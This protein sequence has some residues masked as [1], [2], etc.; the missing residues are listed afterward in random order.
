MYKNGGQ[1]N[2]IDKLIKSDPN[3]L[4]FYKPYII[5]TEMLY[6]NIILQKLLKDKCVIWN[7]PKVY[8]NV[9]GKI[10]HY[11]NNKFVFEKIFESIPKKDNNWF[12][13][14]K[15]NSCCSY[16]IINRISNK[17]TQINRLEYAAAPL[18]GGLWS[19]RSEDIT[20]R[21]TM[22]LLRSGVSNSSDLPDLNENIAI[23]NLWIV[24]NNPTNLKLNNII[25]SISFEYGGM[26]YNKYQT[27]DI[28]NEINILAYIFNIDGI[29]YKNNKIYIP[30]ILPYN[31]L[32]FN[33]SYHD[34]RIH[35]QY[36]DNIT[37]CVT[38]EIW[39]NICDTNA[40]QKLEK[41]NSFS[42]K[43]LFILYKKQYTGI[44]II[45]TIN[46]KIKINFNHPTYVM[47]LMNISKEYVQ[48]IKIFL[49]H[50]KEFYSITEKTA[51]YEYKD[52]TIE[53]FDNHAIIWINKEFLL[54]D[55]LNENINFSVCADPYL[56]IENT[57][58]NQQPVELI[59]INFN[60]QLHQDG[61]TGTVFC[62]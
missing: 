9:F 62:S 26:L 31:T 43:C 47:Y 55:K 10:Q 14:R 19:P 49:N 18:I 54:F 46:N 38:F 50:Y 1:N 12:F 25:K 13:W 32:I 21:D 28:E 53:W 61:M 59:A 52:F 7:C 41:T 29:E 22:S 34:A 60:A 42:H 56:I 51:D 39:G 23:T 8:K 27:T 20:D 30:L 37:N 33:S 45:S 4:I 11:N 6:T 36:N 5:N 15:K 17:N 57:Y 44:D 24:I 35:L 48:S 2:Y 58:E 40:F 3:N 16:E